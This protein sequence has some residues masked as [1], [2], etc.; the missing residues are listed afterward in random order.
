MKKHWWTVI[1]LFLL[2]GFTTYISLDTFV[3]ADA[4]QTNAT[5]MNMAM[6]EN[7]DETADKEN[8]KENHQKNVDLTDSS[9]KKF[10]GKPSKDADE[11]SSDV[12]GTNENKNGKTSEETNKTDSKIKD[13]NSSDSENRT[14][15]EKTGTDSENGTR[16]KKPW[17]KPGNSS[18]NAHSDNKSDAG[19]TENDNNESLVSVSDAGNLDSYKDDNISITIK[20]YEVENT[21]VYVAD[22][23]LKS[24]AYLKTAFAEGTYGKN[25]TAATSDIA[26]DVNA[27]LAINGDYYGAREKGIVIRNGIVYREAEGDS[28]IL[29]IYA[30]GNFKIYE[31]KDVSAQAL[32]EE[33][34]WQAFSFGPSLIEDGKITVSEGDEVGRAKASNPRTAI[35]VIDKLHYVFVVCDGRTGESEGLSLSELAAFMKT[36]GAT[37][38][39]NLDGGGSSTMVFMDKVINNPTSNGKSIKER[40]VSDIVY[41]G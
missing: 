18:D 4:Y 14:R 5:E 37:T 1:Y 10:P 8:S 39:Y 31:S 3:L 27:I 13:K 9:L 7:L 21:A 29:C 23:T 17:T 16:K 6:F 11:S 26:S 36:L 38:A 22:I 30:D 15:K 33:G 25:V 40:S 20:E 35:G 28:Q 12:S 32:V 19:N 2:V 24:A 34:V 41:I